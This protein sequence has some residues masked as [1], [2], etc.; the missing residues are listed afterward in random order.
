M[1]YI[2]T[3]LFL[4]CCFTVKAQTL[5][6]KVSK[7]SDGDTFTLITQGFKKHRVR[8]A[9]ID[10]PESDQPFGVVAGSHLRKLILGKEVTVNVVTFDRYKRP[11]GHIFLGQQNINKEMVKS[12]H[13]WVYRRYSKDKNLLSLESE[14]KRS[15]KGLWGLPKSKRIEPWK[16]RKAKR[17]K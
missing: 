10:A 14:A 12:G 13:A 6:G 9:E 1:K 11:V 2:L 15:K 3:L 16:W 17:P 8:L 4:L 7:V 5:T